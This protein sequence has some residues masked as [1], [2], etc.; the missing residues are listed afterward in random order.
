M[1]KDDEK[2]LV[3]PA[4]ILFEKGRWQGIKS[5]NIDYYLDL[6]K[7]NYQFKR[8]GDVETDPAWKQIIPYIVFSSGGKFFMYTYLSKAGEQRLATSLII[9]VGGHINETDVSGEANVL[10]AGT[11]REWNEEIDYKGTLIEKK[12][13][14]ILNDDARPVEEVHLGLVYHFV[15]D[16]NTIAVK[17]TDTI[18]GELLGLKEIEE[19]IKTNSAGWIGM[20]WRDYLSKLSY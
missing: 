8:R 11:M 9:G 18:A 2:V 6:I 10:E 4:S 5:D 14:G 7:N 19:Q 3:V 13:V 20:V 17:E 1:S 16:S 12:L 15:G